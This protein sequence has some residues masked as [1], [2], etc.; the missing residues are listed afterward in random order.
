MVS[1]FGCTI[2]IYCLK[3]FDGEYRSR[4][5]ISIEIIDEN[6][7]APEFSQTI[8]EASLPENTDAHTSVLQVNAADRDHARNSAIT[9]RIIMSSSN[10]RP[11]FRIN[12]TDG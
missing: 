3:A 11:L 4:T 9:Y 5:T 10:D 2:T 7:H 6:D 12:A 1:L 8:Y